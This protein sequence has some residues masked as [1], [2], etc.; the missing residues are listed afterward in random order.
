M[1]LIHADL[2]GAVVVPIDKAEQVVAA[3]KVIAAQERILIDAA[4]QPGF[5]IEKM[6]AAWKGMSE[7]H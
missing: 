3:A 2:H 1:D 5:N 6:K 7:I 4:R